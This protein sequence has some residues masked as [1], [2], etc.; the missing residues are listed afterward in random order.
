MF[1][2]GQGKSFA[3]VAWLFPLPS[4]KEALEQGTHLLPVFSWHGTTSSHGWMHCGWEFVR[5]RPL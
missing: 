1:F 3:T 2:L 5:P 4:S